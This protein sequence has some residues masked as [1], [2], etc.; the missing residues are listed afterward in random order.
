MGDGN[1]HEHRNLPVVVGGKLGGGFKTGRHLAYPDNTP[2]SNLLVTM[3]DKADVPVER[4][5]DSTGLL[6]ETFMA[7]PLSGV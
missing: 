1:L 3:L 5:G 2:M 7:S 6:K 4:L